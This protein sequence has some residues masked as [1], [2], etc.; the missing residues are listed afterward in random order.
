MGADFEAAF[1]ALKVL[2]QKHSKS[3][4]VGSDTA[5]VY[6]V[7]GRAASPFPQ[8]KGHP[9]W[10]GEVRLGKAYVSFHLI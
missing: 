1:E 3:L 8:H 7:S 2:L 6:S 9:M 4:S 5:T 10:F